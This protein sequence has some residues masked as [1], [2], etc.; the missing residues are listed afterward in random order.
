MKEQ[1]ERMFLNKR[2]RVHGDGSDVGLIPRCRDHTGTVT[3]ISYA[4]DIPESK[5]VFLF[6]FGDGRNFGIQVEQVKEN[7]VVGKTHSL[8][9]FERTITLKEAE[10]SK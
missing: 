10:V 9:P 1:L 2:A 4:P 6:W 8:A 5:Q 7:E 3:R